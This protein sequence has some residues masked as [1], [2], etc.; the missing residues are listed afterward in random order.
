M[1]YAAGLHGSTL[2][3]IAIV[4]PL[5]LDTFGVAVALGLAGLP[6]ERRLQ[7]SLL[8]VGFEMV[9]PLVGAAL[10]APLGDAIGS[11]ADYAAAGLIA[12]LGVYV[13]IAEHGD[14]DEGERLIKMT[15]RGFVGAMALGLSISL[16]ELA[17]GFSAGLLELPILALVVAIGVQTFVVTQLGLRVGSRVRETASE[18][19]ERLAGMALIALGVVLLV[20][21]LTT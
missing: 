4:L 7:I 20:E 8:F 3:L 15:Q 5:G 2:K 19:A 21:Q 6:E 16:D 14:D 13:L 18:I 10:G 12:A 1:P 9:M 17:I 11:V